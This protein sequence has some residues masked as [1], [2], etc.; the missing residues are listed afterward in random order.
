[1]IRIKDETQKQLRR[2]YHGFAKG[3]A[4]RKGTTS[5]ML[6][7]QCVEVIVDGYKEFRYVHTYKPK[8]GSGRAER[9]GNHKSDISNDSL[10]I[11]RLYLCLQSL[12]ERRSEIVE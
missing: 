11:K 4:V 5:T 12:S 8:G 7:S 1:M 3:S 2:S 10:N 9:M 6:L